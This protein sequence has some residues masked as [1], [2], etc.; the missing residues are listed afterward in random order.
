MD[1]VVLIYSRDF[2]PEISILQMGVNG[3]KECAI[4]NMRLNRNSYDF[5]SNLLMDLQNKYGFKTLVLGGGGFVHPMLG[6]NWGIQIKN[7]IKN[8]KS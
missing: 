1:N 5:A 8:V 3:S 4:S 6:Q 2:T 7:F